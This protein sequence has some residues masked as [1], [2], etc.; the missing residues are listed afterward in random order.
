M[1]DLWERHPTVLRRASGVNQALT[2]TNSQTASKNAMT[3]LVLRS[4]RRVVRQPS[5]FGTDQTKLDR[6]LDPSDICARHKCVGFTGLFSE[7]TNVN[8]LTW[9]VCGIVLL[10]SPPTLLAQRRGGHGAGAGRPPAGVSKTD[11]LKDFKRAVALQATPDQVTQFQRLTKSTHAARKSAQDLLQLAE[12]ASKPD[13]FRYTEP[14]T[15]AVGEAQTDDERFLQSFSAVQKSE[16]KDL[17]KKLG[18]A[19]SDV[20]KQTKAL[21]QGLGHSGSDGKQIA[22]VVEKLDKALSDFQTEQLAVSAEMGIQG[23]GS[24]Q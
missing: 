23:E 10:M 13:L 16:L 11:D 20:T 5:T 18:K 8:R 17:T 6:R 19:Q 12:S 4:Y 15:S 2:L 24:S 14:L 1:W 22:S 21:T 7:L 3:Q 9:L